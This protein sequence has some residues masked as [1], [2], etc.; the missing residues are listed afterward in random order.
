M[1]ALNSNGQD[2]YFGHE[3]SYVNQMEDC[4]AVF[5]EGGVAKDPFA[6]FADHGSN[7]V[8]VRLWNYPSWWQDSLEQPEGVKPHCNDY[9]DVKETIRRAKEAGMKVMLR[10]GIEDFEKIHILHSKLQASLK[11]EDH[12]R[13]SEL[14]NALAGFTVPTGEPFDPGSQVRQAR[15][16]LTEIVSCPRWVIFLQKGHWII[17]QIVDH[18]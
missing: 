1:I 14:D 8:R 11:P 18:L 15:K 7:L 10:E 13:L 5:R 17:E 4:G 12:V 2:F 6:I 3:L 9:E 16:L